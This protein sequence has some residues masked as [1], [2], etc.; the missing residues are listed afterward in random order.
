M[1]KSP[2]NHRFFG[3]AAGMI[4]VGAL[5]VGLQAF[6]VSTTSADSDPNVTICHS[7]GNGGFVEITI[8]QSAVTAHLAEHS[9]DFVG[10]CLTSEVTST[11]G[12]EQLET[13]TPAATSTAGAATSTPE[14]TN[15][16]VATST[17][18]PSTATSIPATSTATLSIVTNT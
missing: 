8:D 3:F 16:S 6:G 12:G 11:P 14:V 1:A 5:I 18:V 9:G 13:N 17:S 2:S 4:L 10:P 7:T 15:T